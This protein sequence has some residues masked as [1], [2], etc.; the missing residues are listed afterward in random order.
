M[1]NKHTINQNEKKT[2]HI[3]HNTEF[4]KFPQFGCV[5]I[6]SSS[7]IFIRNHRDFRSFI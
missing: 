7:S 4:I 6:E 5:H 2:P 1:Q 3:I